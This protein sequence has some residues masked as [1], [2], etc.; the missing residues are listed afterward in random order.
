MIHYDSADPH[1]CWV[2]A[3]VIN[4][5]EPK[6]VIAEQGKVYTMH[7]ACVIVIPMKSP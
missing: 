7:P 2:C 4:G 1:L 6:V 3:E 5:E